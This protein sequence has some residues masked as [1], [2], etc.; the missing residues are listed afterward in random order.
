MKNAIFICIM[1]FVNGLSILITNGQTTSDSLYKKEIEQWQ[2]QRE[3]NLRKDDSWL[4][5]AGLFWLKEGKNTFGSAKSN[6]IIFP[7]GDANLGTLIL[8]NGVVNVEILPNVE[9]WQDKNRIDKALIYSPEQKSVILQH[10]SLRWFIIKRGNMYGI[11]LRDLE[12]PAVK[13]FKGVETFPIDQQ[14]QVEATLETAATNHKIPITDVLGMTNFLESPG[15]LVFDLQGKT[16]RLDVVTEDDKLF[17][18]FGD[19]TNGDTTYGSGRFLYAAQPGANGK[20]ILD[21]NKATNPPC[22]FT[23]FA[24]CPLPPRQNILPL[25]IFAGEKKFGEH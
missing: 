11:R 2:A 22:A 17:I 13:A 10:Q 24:T 14:W 23:A 20:T 25:A 6:N 5:L 9:V 19:D 15:V 16:Y 1:L 12:H 4:N 8:K 7:K 3:A 21:F 18:L